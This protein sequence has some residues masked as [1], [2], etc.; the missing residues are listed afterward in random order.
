MKIKYDIIFGMGFDFI[1]IL[2]VFVIIL[3]SMVLHEMAHAYTAFF[4]GDTTAKEEGRLSVNPLKHIDPFLSIMIP[5]LL[6]ILG[7]PIFGGAKPVPIAQKK[8][9]GGEWGMALVAFAGPFMNFL[10]AFLGFL[11]GYYSGLIN[12]G[13]YIGLF[14]KQLVLANLG[15]MIFNLIPIPP[16]DG[17]RILYAIAPDVIRDFLTK[18]ESSLGVFLILVLIYIFGNYLSIFT[19]NIMVAILK[20]FY[21][22]VGR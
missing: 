14:F 22:I 20:F 12:S 18:I 6:F 19:S 2:I 10:I 7:G 5:L 11:I 8:L 15:F 21:F 16:L 4:L 1:A 9:K 3:F 17:S 13:G